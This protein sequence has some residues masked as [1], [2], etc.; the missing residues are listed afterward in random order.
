MLNDVSLTIP[1]KE[2][3]EHM[4]VQRSKTLAHNCF[5][6]FAKITHSRQKRFE[7]AVGKCS[8]A[9]KTGADIVRSYAGI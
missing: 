1:D 9:R 8:L 7:E 5:A 6:W 2:L 4:L 3:S